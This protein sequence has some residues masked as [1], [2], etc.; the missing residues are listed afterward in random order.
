MNYMFT[1]V[2][3]L[4]LGMIM[5]VIGVILYYRSQEK[6]LGQ[7]KQERL[8]AREQSKDELERE[9]RDALV[10]LKDEIHSKRSV[11]LQNDLIGSIPMRYNSKRFMKILSSN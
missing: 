4:G 8:R 1:M 11:A 6:S 5:G 2:G 9:R 10:R 7:I 3:L